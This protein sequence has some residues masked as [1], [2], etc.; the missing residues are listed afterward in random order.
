LI[1]ANL[2]QCDELCQTIDVV[3]RNQILRAEHE[4]LSLDRDQKTLD[5]IAKQ[6]AEL[7]ARIRELLRR[8]LEAQ[9]K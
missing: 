5:E 7:E 9:T 8:K 3:R 6:N 4:M 2:P 1:L